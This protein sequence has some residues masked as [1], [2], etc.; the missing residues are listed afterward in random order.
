[1][2]TVLLRASQARDAWEKTTQIGA[3]G[4]PASCR[5]G[6]PIPQDEGEAKPQMAV[7]LHLGTEIRALGSRT[8]KGKQRGRDCRL[9][10][11]AHKSVYWCRHTPGWETWGLARKSA[12][13]EPYPEPTSEMTQNGG[14][15]RPDWPVTGTFERPRISK[16]VPQRSSPCT[17]IR[18]ASL[19]KGTLG[20]PQSSV[21][22][23]LEKIKFIHKLLN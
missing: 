4:K 18:P 15:V 8:L 13:R 6:F 19:I 21:S 17:R 20:P 23:S 9:P 12:T 22:T 14:Q 3:C 10:H 1:M 2:D 11:R 7:F 5:S 16:A